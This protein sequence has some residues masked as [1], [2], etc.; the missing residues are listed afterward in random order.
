[1]IEDLSHSI[2]RRE[3]IERRIDKKLQQHPFLNLEAGVEAMAKSVRQARID[4]LLPRTTELPEMVLVWLKAFIPMDVVGY[5]KPAPGW[6]GA[7]MVNDPWVPGCWLTDNRTFSNDAYASARM[8]SMLAVTTSTLAVNQLHYCDLTAKIDCDNGTVDCNAYGDASRMTFSN[9][10]GIPNVTFEVDLVGSG[11]NPCPPLG[12]FAPD[13][14]YKGMIAIDFRARQVLFQGFLDQFPAFEMY[15]MAY[16]SSSPW[17]GTAMF[18][19]SVHET[20][21]IVR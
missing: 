6:D 2:R 1:M 17:L 18:Q 4:Q 21:K 5:T 15:A 19:G 9:P 12:V 3:A 20:E 13:I 11:A 7:T 8:T 16:T 14:D 10:R